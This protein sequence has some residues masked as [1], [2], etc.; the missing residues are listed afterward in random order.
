[1]SS[2]IDLK[3]KSV[4][5]EH[6]EDVEEEVRNNSKTVE[7][8]SAAFQVFSSSDTYAYLWKL[9]G[10]RGLEFGLR[11]DRRSGLSLDETTINQKKRIGRVAASKLKRHADPYADRIRVFG[12]N[13]PP[14]RQ[15][16]SV[17]EL[18]LGACNDNILILLSIVAFVSLSLGLYQKFAVQ[19]ADNKQRTQWVESVTIIVVLAI[20]VI[21]GAVSDWG[22][23]M[24]FVKLN[25][26]EE[27]GRMVTVIRSGRYIRIPV[28]GLL[29]GDVCHLEPGDVI[30]VDGVLI[31][32]HIKCSE[33]S[34]R[35][36]DEVK[37]TPI[38]VAMLHLGFDPDCTLDPFI[39][40]GSEAL[41]GVGTFL[42]TAVVSFSDAL[43]SFHA[44]SRPALLQ[45][46]I[47]NISEAIA[48][49]GGCAALLLFIIL[50]IKFL[51]LLRGSEATGFEKGQRF[52]QII[53]LTVTVSVLAFPLGLPLAADFAI[54]TA[55][56]RMLK[57]NNLVRVRNIMETVGSITTLCIDETG[58]LTQ[59]KMPVVA[60][61]WGRLF[62]PILLHSIAVNST[63]LEADQNSVKTHLDMGPL[64]EERSGKYMV[65]AIKRPGGNYR[66]FMKGAPEVLLQC[67]SLRMIGFTYRDLATW[68]PENGSSMDVVEDMVWLGLFGIQDPL[69]ADALK[70]V[71]TLQKAGVFIRMITGDNPL[72]AQ[73]MAS[74]CGI[75]TD[76]G[77]CIEGQ[78]FRQLSS[79]QQD[80]VLPRLQVLSR[81]TSDDKRRL[82]EGLKARGK[83][84]G[85]VGYGT[86][87]GPAL[88]S[89]DVAFSMAAGTE[90]AK[91]ISSVIIL[92]N[93]FYSST[94]AI[95][96]G[97][98]ITDV[99]KRYLQL[100]LTMIIAFIIV[101]FISAVSY[102]AE[103]STLSV[104][105]ILWLCFI[106]DTISA[107][108]VSTDPPDQLTMDRKPEPKSA[109]LVTANMWKMI[110]GQA[111]HQISV[112]L[113]LYFAG[114]RI[115]RNIDVDQLNTLIFNTFVTRRSA[116]LIA[117][118][119]NW[120][121]LG[122]NLLL[123]GG[124][125][126]VVF[127]GGRAFSVKRLSA[128]QWAVSVVL[129]LLSIPLG[130]VFK[131][132]PD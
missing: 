36:S 106:I 17:R 2:N 101:T 66:I 123:I 119:R 61:T 35:K 28:Y 48:K 110:L 25:K 86:D 112:T 51:V 115:F 91:G 95:R 104:V 44:E 69:Q 74:E 68:P 49:L 82:V 59:N 70:A 131:V 33:Y 80:Q 37:K 83:T 128:P 71:L 130:M 126:A 12:D 19:Q 98:A 92:D 27:E 129:G 20:V 116:N 43:R 97:R 76:G 11:T 63:A 50:L 127:V 85:V 77:L 29:V 41:E 81:C 7:A 16:R 10:L 30:P 4:E 65:S 108:A 72:A 118:T 31:E 26:K 124:Q 100:Q 111:I 121:F 53:L 114:R 57:Q 109:P 87:D 107:F 75:Y 84:V 90:A 67:Q 24:Q 88:K 39:I 22:N 54:A 113:T 21:V 132:I 47:N 79:R 9:G 125:I 105:Q 6:F 38:D 5:R 102:G 96:W 58:G 93:A 94:I 60:A 99:V 42:V 13:R 120:Y 8:R 40:S 14:E 45:L 56:T 52:L 15:I 3:G 34:D 1:M 23:E 32:G 103:A 89:A 18:I 62:L 73:S 117:F 55:T 122:L 78:M 64:A 46:K